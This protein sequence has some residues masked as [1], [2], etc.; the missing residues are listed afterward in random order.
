MVDVP[1]V[2]V[3]VPLGIFVVNELIKFTESFRFPFGR[4][5]EHLNI[6]SVSS[7]IQSIEGR[8]QLL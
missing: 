2:I 7:L 4:D 3:T 5:S 1:Q 8:Y 6:H